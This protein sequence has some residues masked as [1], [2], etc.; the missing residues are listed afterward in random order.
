V[1][2]RGRGWFVGTGI[3]G[4]PSICILL[5]RTRL[6]SVLSLVFQLLVG[7]LVIGWPVGGWR[8]VGHVV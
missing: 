5:I 2:V 8:L 4:V 6:I 7:Q 1:D 3:I